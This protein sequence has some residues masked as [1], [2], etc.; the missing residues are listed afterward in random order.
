MNY[1]ERWDVVYKS[2]Q[3]INFS[4]FDYNTVKHALVEHIRLHYPENFNNFIESDEF[5]MIL[6][7]FAYISELFAYRLDMNAHEN[8]IGT[9]GRKESVLRLAQLI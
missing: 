8:F 4:A 2:F 3:Q 5:V 9:A 7:S 6:E 1:A